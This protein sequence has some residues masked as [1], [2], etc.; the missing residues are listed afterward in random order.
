MML[1]YSSDYQEAATSIED[2]IEKVLEL[3]YRT[4]DIARGGE[5]VSTVEM[6]DAIIESLKHFTIESLTKTMSK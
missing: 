5:Y 6:G 1:R 4:K 2:A 3:G